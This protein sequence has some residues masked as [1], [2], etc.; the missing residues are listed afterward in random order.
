MIRTIIVDDEP[1]AVNFVASAL[2]KY[3]S[4]VEVVAKLHTVE[5]AE[6]VVNSSSFDLL[7]LDIELLDGTGFDLLEKVENRDFFLIF[8]TAYNQHAVK[9]FKYSA[10]DYLLKPL[11]IKELLS[12][13][14][15]IKQR[16]DRQ[17][18]PEQ[19]IRNL[20]DN[21]KGNK[22]EKLAINAQN[23]TLFVSL[24]DIIRFEAYGNYSKVFLQN[25]EYLASKTLKEFENLLADST[26]FRA[27]HSHIVNIQYL[28][29]YVR[30]DG[31]MVLM[32]DGS[33]I[34]VAT[35]RK[36]SFENFLKQHFANLP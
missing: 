2:Q 6:L 24:S 12:A 11:N 7:L 4:D 26:F 22:I 5:D 16:K 32:N 29:K 23:E 8:I 27:H 14:D 25:G 28:K 15:K 18:K 9:A 17:D 3:C 35:R 13:I 30:K 31:L 33:S 20:L 21:L 10:V 19:D 1:N 36:E 34:P